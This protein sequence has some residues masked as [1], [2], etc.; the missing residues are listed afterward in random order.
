MPLAD[1]SVP[2]ELTSALYSGTD[3]PIN[4]AAATGIYLLRPDGCSLATS[5]RATKEDMPQASGSILHPRYLTGMEMTLVVQLWETTQVAACNET[6]QVMLD[7]IMGY[8]AALLNAGDNQGRIVWTPDG[9]SS[10]MLDDIRLLTYPEESITD[11][12]ITE[13]TFTVDTRFPYAME[14]TELQVVLDASEVVTN[15]GNTYTYPV[16]RVNG[17][18]TGFTLSNTTT[19]AQLVYDG[20]RP[21]ATGVTSPS[22]IELDMFRNTAYLNG[23]GA[24][25]KAGIDP[26]LSEFFPLAP[27]ANT[28][29][30]TGAP[31]GLAL[32]NGAWA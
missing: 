19:G 17:T 32:I 2:F 20:T 25:M 5:V 6:S 23:S 9:E 15:L 13:L 14:E 21:G 11:G 12:G 27:G 7:E 8:V 30:L 26:L 22:Y 24:N 1:W 4:T 31:S 29:T 18:F 3:L 10:R 16:I 28:I